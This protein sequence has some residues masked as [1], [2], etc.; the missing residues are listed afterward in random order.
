[1]IKTILYMF[2]NNYKK[3]YRCYSAAKCRTGGG[4]TW[5]WRHLFE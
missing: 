1:M 4:V 2:S 5:R 3:I